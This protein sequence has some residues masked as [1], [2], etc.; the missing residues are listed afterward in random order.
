M[1]TLANIEKEIAKLMKEKE[2]LLKKEIKVAVQQARELIAQF[3][4][5][6]ADL[7][8]GKKTRSAKAGVVVAA[9]RAAKVVA[10]PKYRDLATGKTWT[11]RG[12]PPNW[13]AGVKDRAAFLITAEGTEASAPASSKQAA[14][15]APKKAAR[16]VVAEKKGAVKK[17]VAAKVARKAVAVK[18]RVARKSGKSAQAEGST[19]AAPAADPS[20]GGSG[21]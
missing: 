9:K 11:G 20:G 12:K 1:A 15:K 18:A 10:T 6:A 2:A 5:T 17:A 14:A 4:L 19:A 3:G 21:S 13:I 7:G 8:F 16:K